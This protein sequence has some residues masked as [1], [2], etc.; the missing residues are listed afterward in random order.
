MVESR[1]LLS[2]LGGVSLAAAESLF[3]VRSLHNVNNANIMS[4]RRRKILELDLTFEEEGEPID[5]PT[6]KL[7]LFPIQSSLDSNGE[8]ILET[9]LQDY[10]TAF[11]LQQYPSA[12]DETDDTE[13]VTPEFKSATVDVV[14]SKAIVSDDTRRRQLQRQGMELNIDTTLRFVDGVFPDDSRLDSDMQKAF[15]TNF[16]VFLAEYLPAYAAG[17]DTELDGIDSGVYLTGFTAPPT[18]SPSVSVQRDISQANE[19]LENNVGG[20]GSGAGYL[21]YTAIGAGVAMF[22]LTALVLSAKRRRI[23]ADRK[24]GY[25]DDVS[26]GSRAHVSIDFDGRQEAMELERERRDEEY[27]QREI[28]RRLKASKETRKSDGRRTLRFAKED[29]PPSLLETAVSS[30]SWETNPQEQEDE[31]W[32]YLNNIRLSSALV[33]DDSSQGEI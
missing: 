12:A 15:F 2:L 29:P 4:D 8:M 32:K 7:Q 5:L 33:D 28:A 31:D 3:R 6:Y 16:D 24:S 9:A 17:A 14:D 22:V 13:S 30:G 23:E 19:G 11:F 20:E 10:L 18:S 1:L 25:D 27:T 21:L 26:V